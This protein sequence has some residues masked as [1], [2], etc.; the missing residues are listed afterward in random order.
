MQ[1][2]HELRDALLTDINQRERELDALRNKM[3]GIDAAIAA[4]TG[5]NIPDP[6]RRTRRN[7]KGTVMDLIVQAGKAGVTAHEIVDQAAV[8]GRQLDRPSVSSLLSRLKREG[9]LSFDG[10]R[11]YP[12]AGR[13]IENSPNLKVVGS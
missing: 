13:D 12:V 7:V 2:L 10:E 6:R 5:T 8:G 1:K 9:V 11:Y 4:I 3:K